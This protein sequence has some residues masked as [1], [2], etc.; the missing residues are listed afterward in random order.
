MLIDDDP[1]SNFITSNIIYNNGFAETVVISENP[2]EA[3]ALLKE[4]KVNPDIIFLDV[5]MPNMDGFLFLD[6][7]G[8]STIDKSRT[9]I[10]MLSSSIRQI[11]IQRAEKNK[12]VSRFISKALTAEL[13]LELANF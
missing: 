2:G 6:E 8:K 13:L 7:Y 11:D 10:V 4:G 12:Y 9:K 5:L 1:V 3:L